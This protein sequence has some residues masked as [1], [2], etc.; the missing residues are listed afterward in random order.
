MLGGIVVDTNNFT[1]KTSDTTYENASYLTKI[2][3]DTKEVQY[4]LKENLKEL[5]KKFN[6]NLDG[7]LKD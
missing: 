2:G 4:L 6:T 1:L 3:G 5:E 7:G